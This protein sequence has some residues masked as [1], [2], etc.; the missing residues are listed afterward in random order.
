MRPMSKMLALSAEWVDMLTSVAN[1]PHILTGLARRKTTIQVVLRNGLQIEVPRDMIWLVKNNFFRRVYTPAPLHIGVRDVVVDIGAHVGAFTIWA[2]SLTCQT[3]YA[4]E[5][6]PSSFAVLERNIEASHLTNVVTHRSAVS[7]VAGSAQL[8]LHHNTSLGNT[9]HFR[10]ENLEAYKQPDGTLPF[11]PPLADSTSIDVLTTT[12]P[13]IMDTYHLE[14]IDFLKLDCEGSEGSILS[15]LPVVYL[16]RIQQIALE[17]HDHLSPVRHK[18][19]QRLLE[20]AGFCVKVQWTP[21]SA[22][23]YL[24]AWKPK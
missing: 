24:Y 17:F 7:D 2:A 11:V 5:P 23:G 22:F 8:L 20:D 19:L 1:W 12:L 6:S 13:A 9:L 14:C 3:V 4:F 21:P 18:D 16:Q 15:S 10:P